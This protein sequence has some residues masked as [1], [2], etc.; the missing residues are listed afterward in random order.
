MFNLRNTVLDNLYS[1]SK[2]GK[3]KHNDT[4]THYIITLVRNI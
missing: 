4:D 3:M 2:E 1:I